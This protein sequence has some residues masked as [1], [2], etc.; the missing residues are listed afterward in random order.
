[1][2]TP[3]LMQVAAK[4]LAKELNTPLLY[5]TKQ[6]TEERLENIRF[7]AGILKFLAEDTIDFF[8]DVTA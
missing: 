7:L 3:E 8:S 6:Q 5:E 2:C 4:K 1:M